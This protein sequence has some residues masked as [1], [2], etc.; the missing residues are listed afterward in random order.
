MVSE[1]TIIR[2][3]AYR[4]EWT[5]F[6]TVEENDLVVI[7]V[8][9]VVVAEAYILKCGVFTFE[10]VTHR[11]PSLFLVN[12]TQI[13][14]YRLLFVNSTNLFDRKRFLSSEGMDCSLPEAMQRSSPFL[15]FADLQNAKWTKCIV[16]I[17]NI[18]VD[19][20]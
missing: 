11:D 1:R 20:R 3:T 18:K 4:N 7:V 5:L 13:S 14:R 15:T 9:D 2:C 8:Q 6:Q 17:S 19:M 16:H 10:R 12:L